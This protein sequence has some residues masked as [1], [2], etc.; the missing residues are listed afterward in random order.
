[1]FFVGITFVLVVLVFPRGLVGAIQKR[2][3]A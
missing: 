1:M 3:G 2:L